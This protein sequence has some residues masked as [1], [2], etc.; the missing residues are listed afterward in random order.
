M[1]EI[2]PKRCEGRELTKDQLQRPAP[3]P[4]LFEQVDRSAGSA[5]GD[6]VHRPG[7][8]AL[9]KLQKEGSARQQTLTLQQQLRQRVAERCAHLPPT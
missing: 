4:P 9:P 6:E 5:S 8:R 1:G 3:A 2:R 7:G